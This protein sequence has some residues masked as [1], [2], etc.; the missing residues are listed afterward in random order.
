MSTRTA[1][2]N[3]KRHYFSI[4]TNLWHEA[5]TRRFRPFLSLAFSRHSNRSTALGNR[6]LFIQHWKKT[7]M[8]EYSVAVFIIIQWPPSS[9]CP[10]LH[11]PPNKYNFTWKSRR[12]LESYA[13]FQTKWCREMRRGKNTEFPW[14]TP[15]RLR[16][17]YLI[18]NPHITTPCCRT[19]FPNWFWAM[20]HIYHQEIYIYNICNKIL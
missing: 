20:E 19:V 8:P 13:S 7:K 5:A 16:G 11:L 4:L 10:C 17:S 6:S 2:H 15:E 12:I 14:T 3:H 9:S 1:E 18:Q